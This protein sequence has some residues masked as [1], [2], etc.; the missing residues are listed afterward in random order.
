MTT[1]RARLVVLASGGGSNL[2][3]ILDACDDRRIAADVV[4]VVS[5]RAKAR[6]LD[7]ARGAG[8]AAEH[9]DPAP[10]ADRRA[11]DSSLAQLV[12]SHSPDFVVL[13]GWMRLLSGSFLDAFPDRVLNL[14]PALPGELPGLHAIERAFAEHEAGRRTGS[15]VMVHLV[16]DEL[17]DAGPVLGSAAV[18]I[19]ADD[20]LESFAQRMHAAEHRLLVDV[21]A[22]L[23]QTLN[24]NPNAEAH[25]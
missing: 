3:A 16:P 20:T 4:A 18:P 7:R 22:S 14:H 8:V 6:A 2:Q 13:A 11:Y 19:R 25:R 12:A 24:P 9:L 1:R 21:V 10:A 5:D 15:G 23:C 17:V